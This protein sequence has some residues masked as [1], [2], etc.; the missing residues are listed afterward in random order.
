MH[1]G[2]GAGRRNK[3][4]D[5]LQK[6]TLWPWLNGKIFQHWY[7]ERELTCF[8]LNVIHK[9]FNEK[10]HHYNTIL[11]SWYIW[12]LTIFSL[13]IN[14][15]VLHTTDGIMPL[16]IWGKEVFTN[17]KHQRLAKTEQNWIKMKVLIKS[18]FLNIQRS[19]KYVEMNKL[20]YMRLNEWTK[21][22]HTMNEKGKCLLETFGW[23]LFITNVE[24]LQNVKSIEH[25][26]LRLSD[27]CLENLL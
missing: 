17:R 4:E 24:F 22:T 2:K 11:S 14:L 6:G 27:E 10:L 16:T 19:K 21:K 12:V 25:A 26:F 3:L 8:T 15:H 5:F 7:T 13:D 18:G 20:K 1:W 9:H 23:H